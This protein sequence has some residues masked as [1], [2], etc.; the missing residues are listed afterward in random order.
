MSCRFLGAVA[1]TVPSVYF[2]LHRVLH[3]TTNIMTSTTIMNTRTRSIKEPAQEV[4]R[5][6]EED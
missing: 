2:M 5:A 6:K 4:K 1:V 3:L